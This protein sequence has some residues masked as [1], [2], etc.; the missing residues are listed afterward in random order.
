M[1]ADEIFKVKL[2]A[3]R[4][5]QHEGRAAF[6]V[7]DM[8]KPCVQKPPAKTVIVIITLTLTQFLSEWIKDILIRIVIMT[9]VSASLLCPQSEWTHISGPLILR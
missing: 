4:S 3:E 8:G 9:H 7:G 5:R 1:R 6:A 2:T